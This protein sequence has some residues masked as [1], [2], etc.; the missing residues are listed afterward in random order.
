MVMKTHR[1]LAKLA[2]PV[3][4]LLLL[5]ATVAVT[6]RESP[7]V[8]SVQVCVK[9]N[10]QLRVLTG[11]TPTCDPSERQMEWVIG[12]EVTDLQIGQGLVG[13][14]EDGTI[15][16]AVD[17]ELIQSC[18]SCNGGRVFAGFDDGP[19]VTP[20]GADAPNHGDP[21]PGIGALRVPEGKYLV[22][23]KLWIHNTTDNRLFARCKL[24]AGSTFDWVEVTVR[25]R[26]STAVSLIMVHEF[27]EPEGL[28]LVGCS[29]NQLGSG[30]E[31]NDLKITAVEVSDIS[32]LFLGGD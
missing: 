18:T 26:D 16:L 20:A 7:P 32:N 15:Q 2:I 4:A 24:S 14:R 27:N 8:T 17:P 28:A 29:D 21:L 9:D 5:G 23:A 31:W 12:G 13:S 3:V 25:E 11:N 22:Q 30:T 10:G 6:Q 1:T 19:G